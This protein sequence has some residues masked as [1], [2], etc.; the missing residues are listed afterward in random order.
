V[1]NQILNRSQT[2]EFILQMC[3]RHRPGWKFTRVSA[4]AFTS[5][6]AE[7]RVRIIDKIKRLPAVGRTVR[8]D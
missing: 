7:L 6:E 3:E 5:I 8:F 4:D 2:R 1:R